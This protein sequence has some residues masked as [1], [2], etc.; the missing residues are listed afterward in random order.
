MI[1]DI[2]LYEDNHLIIVNK[3]S[4][5]IVQGDKT[6]DVPLS[7]KIKE[8][9]KVKYDKPG[10]VYLGLPHRLDRPTSGIVVF[11]KTSKALARVNKIFHDRK[12]NKTYWALVEKKPIPSRGRLENYLAKNEK[13]NKSFVVDPQQPGA[14]KAALS[15]QLLYSLKKY[16]LVE[17][18][19]ETGRHHQIRVQLSHRG[20]SIKG[21]VKYGAHRTNPDASIC[22]HARYLE[23]DHPTT[24]E[25]LK[26][27]APVPNDNLWKDAEK[28][29]N[30]KKTH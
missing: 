15:Y 19:L 22:L 17:V 3:P 30:S 18:A 25:K 13:R 29:V 28:G 5:E 23:F 20:W 26:I 27:T 11:A 21:D 16:F 7:E 9:I 8:Y 24:G 14:Q 2:I 1:Q 4:G 10:N 6:G 12:V